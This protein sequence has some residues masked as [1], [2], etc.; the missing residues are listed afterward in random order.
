[1][2]I[3]AVTAYGIALVEHA[4]NAGSIAVGYVGLAAIVQPDAHV[5]L[6]LVLAL[7]A[8][9]IAIGRVGGWR[10]AWPA[11]AS[12]LLVALVTALLGVRLHGFEG[13]ALLAFA[14]IAYLVAMIESRAEALLLAL[15]IGVLALAAGVRALEW[16]LW[17]A[18]LAFVGL[19]WLYVAGQWLWGALPWL[20]NGAGHPWWMD[21]AASAAHPNWQDVRFLGRII[22]HLAG[23]IVGSGVVLVAL[24]IAQTYTPGE[25]LAEVE[26]V[27][28]ASL[29][30]LF[31]LSARVIPVHALWYVAGGLLAVAVSWQ[32]RWLGA[33]NIQA[34]VLAPGSY[35]L[36][37]GALLPADHRL[38]NPVR[39]G[40]LAS[41]SGALLLL[42]PTLTQS[43]TTPQT[44][45]WVY[46]AVLALE[47]LVIAAIGVGTHSRALLLLGTGF[48]GLAAIRGALLAF[49]S[50]VPVALIIAALALLLMGG[51]TWLSQR[52]RREASTAQ[53]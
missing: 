41:L 17:Q 49:S 23:L 40:Q 52:V 24:L 50:G 35:L 20:R 13:W 22:H 10:W 47:A 28:L 6:P 9:G 34:F 14:L 25:P 11:Y 44:E 37:I 45:N 30:M 46:A 7:A 39:L 42:L 51:A 3:F 27:A 26:V 21:V 19:S 16:P 2:L 29:A 36:I 5:L 43:F 8:V 12:S 32:V 33:D 18:A 53:L 48:F 4:P 1:L 15:S 31:A 38:R